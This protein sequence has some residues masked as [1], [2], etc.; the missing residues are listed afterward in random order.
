M[1]GIVI[2]VFGVY[3]LHTV[4]EYFFNGV[5]ITWLQCCVGVSGS[6]GSVGHSTV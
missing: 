2:D 4:Y 5:C 6:R 1:L 3:Q